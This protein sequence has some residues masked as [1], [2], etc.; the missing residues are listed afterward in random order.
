VP[1]TCKTAG[2][3][4]YEAAGA[5]VTEHDAPPKAFPTWE[6]LDARAREYWDRIGSAVR[7]PLIAALGVSDLENRRRSKIRWEHST[8]RGLW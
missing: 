5:W 7:A 2:Q 3:L 1:E 6:M 4:A 8:I